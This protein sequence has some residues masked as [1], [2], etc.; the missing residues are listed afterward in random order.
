MDNCIYWER[1]M[2]YFARLLL[3]SDRYPSHEIIISKL[4]KKKMKTIDNILRPS[5]CISKMDDVIIK[6]EQCIICLEKYKIREYKRQLPCQHHFHKKCID[7]WLKTKNGCPC[8]RDD[9]FQSS[10]KRTIYVE[11]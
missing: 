1:Y 3:Q 2:Q 7:K 10:Q 5:E 4:K 11:C 6:N 8:C 9:C